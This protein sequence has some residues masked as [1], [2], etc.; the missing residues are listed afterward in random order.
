VRRL[1]PR[2]RER[3]DLGAVGHIVTDALRAGLDRPGRISAAIAPY[4]ARLKLPPG[5]GVALLAWLLD[6]TSAPERD[7]WLKQ[8]SA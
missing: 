7:E 3:E 1:R 8:A 5:D 2:R 6:L 4:A